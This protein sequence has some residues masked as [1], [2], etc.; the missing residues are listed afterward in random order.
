MD[1]HH[2]CTCRACGH[3]V[4]V[5]RKSRPE[6]PSARYPLQTLAMTHRTDQN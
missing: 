3:Q 5:M 2:S 6:I 4:Q 1:I